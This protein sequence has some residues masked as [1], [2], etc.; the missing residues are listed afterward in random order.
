MEL[1]NDPKILQSIVKKAWE[2]SEFKKN[3]KLY[4]I[5]TLEDFFGEPVKLPAGKK[6]A[7]IDHSDTSTFF[8]NIPVQ[9]I[10]EDLEL[11]E[12]QLDFISGGGDP[13]YRPE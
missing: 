13:M 3:L 10:I 6:I 7:I 2:D 8:I 5:A 1:S 12:A 11:N 4:P 9:E